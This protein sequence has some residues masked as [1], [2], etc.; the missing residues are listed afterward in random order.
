MPPEAAVANVADDFNELFRSNNLTPLPDTELKELLSGVAR[1]LTVNDLAA[2]IVAVKRFDDRP[3][4]VMEPY[5]GEHLIDMESGRVVHWWHLRKD[6]EVIPEFL[7]AS[8]RSGLTYAESVDLLQAVVDTNRYDFGGVDGI[9]KAVADILDMSHKRGVSF[10]PSLDTFKRFL[11][12]A[13]RDGEIDRAFGIAR[14]CMVA[15]MSVEQSLDIVQSIYDGTGIAGYV[16]MALYDELD[17]LGANGAGGD[18]LYKALKAVHANGIGF[19]N[20]TALVH[21]AATQTS[22]S[23]TDIF[24]K[25]VAGLPIEDSTS[26]RISDS[27]ADPFVRVANALL[28]SA[29]GEVSVTKA[30][31]DY[32]PEIGLEKL[33]HGVLPYRLAR[34]LRDGFTD[35]RELMKTAHTEGAWVFDP[36]SE[37]WFSLGGR[38]SLH[39]GRARHEFV[40]YDVSALSSNPVFVH[41]HP[42]NN[43]VFISPQRD[44]LAF[45]QLQKKLVSFLTAMPSGSDFGLLSD[46]GRVAAAPVEITGLIVTSQGITEFRAP[47][48]AENVKAFAESFKFAKGDVMSV[49]DAAGYLGK[50][51]IHEPDFAFIE[52][53]LPAVREKLPS[54]FEIS[55]SAFEDFDFDRLFGDCGERILPAPSMA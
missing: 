18:L 24:E 31:L 51:G 16:F 38:T 32:F 27:A 1:H 11:V 53:L 33:V 22:F 50:H 19:P 45:P 43:E 10:R 23:H 40:P 8:A 54:G 52:R 37:T 21:A 49:F 35:L 36:A 4:H 41:I 17:T 7:D 30:V 20:F 14:L 39:V 28:P 34:S 42:E 25:L 5:P 47:P 46:L 12:E 13:R 44:T 55:V 48:N 29:R 9:I 15:G 2:Y 3:V 6:C 26:K